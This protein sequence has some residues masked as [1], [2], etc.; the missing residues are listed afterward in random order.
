M[1]RLG[2]R[3]GMRLVRREMKML[4]TTNVAQNVGVTSLSVSMFAFVTSWHIV[5][6]SGESLGPG[7]SLWESGM[8]V[9]FCGMV[10]L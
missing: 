2:D 4:T 3:L 6:A 1:L 10:N 7:C 9:E 8:L 5:A